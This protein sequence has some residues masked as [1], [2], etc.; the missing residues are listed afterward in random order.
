MFAQYLLA[1]PLCP[2]HPSPTR[3]GRSL[4]SEPQRLSRK[5]APAMPPLGAEEGREHRP[6]GGAAPSGNQAGEAQGD[7][8]MEATCRPD[9]LFCVSQEPTGQ[10]RVLW[11]PSCWSG[12]T[13]LL[14]SSTNKAT[15]WQVSDSMQ[16]DTEHPCHIPAHQAHGCFVGYCL[17]QWERRPPSTLVHR[18]SHGTFRGLK[19]PPSPWSTGT[20]DGV[21]EMRG[22]NMCPEGSNPRGSRAWKAQEAR[23]SGLGGHKPLH[24]DPACW[25]LSSQGRQRATQQS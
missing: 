14:L 21:L 24:P 8:R 11:G 25:R 9:G 4:Q 6:G 16:M 17:R 13:L 18:H 22:R 19:T 12:H 3:H 5:Q 7:L 20:K 1:S 10:C 23:V 15:V 2:Q